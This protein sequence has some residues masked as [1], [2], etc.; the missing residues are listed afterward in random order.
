[1]ILAMALSRGRPAL[2]SR[3][4]SA[5]PIV[6]GHGHV[7]INTPLGHATSAAKS[8]TPVFASPHPRGHRSGSAL[9]PG[10]VSAPVPVPTCQRIDVQSILIKRHR[11]SDDSPFSNP[12][13]MPPLIPDPLPE[14]RYMAVPMGP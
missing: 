8:R 2:G 9:G 4:V 10:S 6:S 5:A 11:V 12:R 1:M 7:S 14:P 3:P 13:A